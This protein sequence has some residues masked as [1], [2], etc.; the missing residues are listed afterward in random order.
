MYIYCSGSA[1]LSIP[2]VPW[3]HGV[4]G[5][6]SLLCPSSGAFEAVS[7]TA[8]LYRVRGLCDL[9]VKRSDTDSGPLGTR[10]HEL[11]LAGGGPIAW[12]QLKICQP[13]HPCP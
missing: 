3:F 10:H 5:C 2:R 9:R 12:C 13:A 11:S 1:I 6:Q 4:Q 7:F 8:S